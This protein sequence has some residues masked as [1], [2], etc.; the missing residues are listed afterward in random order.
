MFPITAV[1]VQKAVK[2]N[3]RRIEK[4][5]GFIRHGRTQ[6]TFE[7]MKASSGEEAPCSDELLFMIQPASK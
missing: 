1:K 5:L 7:E 4:R 3:Q 6:E 2:W